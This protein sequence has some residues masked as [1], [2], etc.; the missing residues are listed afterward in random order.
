MIPINNMFMCAYLLNF[1]FSMCSIVKA[2][3]VL[4]RQCV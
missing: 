3:K 4:G 1:Y 2:D